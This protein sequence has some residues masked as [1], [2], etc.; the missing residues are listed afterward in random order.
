MTS[1]A[2]SVE[3]S[4][5]DGDRFGISVARVKMEPR[6]DLRPVNEYC[7]ENGVA[8]LIARCPASELRTAQAMEQDGFSLMDTLIYYARNLR[9]TPIPSDVGKVPIRPVQP[10]DEDAV[11]GV[12]AESFKGYFGHYHADER[13]DR[14]ECDEVYRDWAV[15]SCVSRDVADEV[16]L[17]DL[18]GRIVGFATLRLNSADEGEGILFGVAPEAQGHGIYR[19]FMVRGM[20]WCASK[21]A[22]S[23]VVSTQMTNYAVQ[24]VWVR[25]GFEPS[26][27]YYTFHKWFEGS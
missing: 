4:P 13:L 10:G 20:E 14:K 22:T 8:L 6:H 7:R 19:S 25:V 2:P 16:L 11:E 27:A 12:A 9:K 26:H 24:K 1:E 23:M 21:G 18:D 3:L 15:R 17:A 5:I